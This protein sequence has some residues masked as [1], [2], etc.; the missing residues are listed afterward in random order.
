MSDTTPTVVL[1]HGAFAENASWNPVIERLAAKGITAFSASNELRSVGGDGEYVADIIRSVDGPVILV[2]HSY[3]GVVITQASS[4][5]ENV[6]ALVYVAAFAPDT[7]ESASDLAGKYPGSTLGEALAATTLTSGEVDLT[8]RRDAFHHQFCADVDE[9]TAALMWAT[10]R[11]ITQRA[12]NEPLPTATPGWKTHPSW[13]IYAGADLNIPPAAV[14]FVAERAQSKA[15]V[16]VD[17]ASH[18]V[19]VSQPDL[20][21]ESILAA[22]A[23]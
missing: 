3:G 9:A 16:R 18:A 2:G 17:G 11:P 4:L 1:V 12:L 22:I 15:L 14:E 19:A 23:G 8:I 7:G 6:Q 13:F 20:V 5:V 21:V 10:Q